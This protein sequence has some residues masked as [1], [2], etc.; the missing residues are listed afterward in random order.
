MKNT[1]I[2]TILTLISFNY[3][4]AQTQ[5]INH[6]NKEIA[7]VEKVDINYLLFSPSNTQHNVAGKL[8]LII[9]LHGAGERGTDIKKVKVHGP[10]KIVVSKTD[11]GFYVLSPQCREN[12][13]WNPKL[14]SQLLDEVLVKNKNIDTNRIYLTGLSMGG[15]GTYDWA[16]LEP[17]RF[18]AIAPIC[19]GSDTHTRLVN[20]FKHIPIWIF[21]GAMD[22]IVDINSSIAIARVLKNSE[23]NVQFTIYPFANHNS[24]TE[25]YN[26]PEL[27]KWFLTNA[28]NK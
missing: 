1:F 18:A 26:N 9:F 19:G 12:K 14:L 27:Y 21:H 3:T 7:V 10:P 13:R 24:W 4:I 22:Q 20:A 6:L 5:S 23:A 8:P 17:N 25:T 11:F 28:L 15:Y 16:I 2:I